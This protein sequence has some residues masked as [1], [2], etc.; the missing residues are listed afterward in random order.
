[1]VCFSPRHDLTLPELDLP[2]IENVLNTLI[3]LNIFK[4]KL[5]VRFEKQKKIYYRLGKCY[6]DYQAYQDY[7]NLGKIHMAIY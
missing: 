7:Y 4:F 5:A 2:T 1:M 3:S 6:N